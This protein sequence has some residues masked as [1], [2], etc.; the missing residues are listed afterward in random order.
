MYIKQVVLDGFKSYAQRTEIQ[1][2]DPEFNAITGLNGSGK[3]NILD[4]ICFLLGISNLSQ[5]KALPQYTSSLPPS[6]LLSPA[7]C[8]QAAFKSWCTRGGRLGSPRLPSQLPLT[9]ETSS[10]AL[11]ATKPTTN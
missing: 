6:C 1:G 10:R 7:R 9:T 11:S 4:A 8:V 2:F 3:S 5:V